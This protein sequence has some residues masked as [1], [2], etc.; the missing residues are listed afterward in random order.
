MRWLSLFL[1]CQHLNSRTNLRECED[2]SW[3]MVQ[4]V[5]VF[6][7]DVFAYPKLNTTGVVGR[8][9]P[10]ACLE[11]KNKMA[12]LQTT[13]L[14]REAATERQTCRLAVR[15]AAGNSICVNI[16][17]L[18]LT[19]RRYFAFYWAHYGPCSSLSHFIWFCNILKCRESLARCYSNAPSLYYWSDY[20]PSV[21]LRNCSYCYLCLKTFESSKQQT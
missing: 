4:A 8:M 17:L 14:D 20:K 12:P 16:S 9:G 7:F 3:F 11:A 2:Q 15:L 10:R 5:P 21:T 13:L 1:A 6:L 18:R 19:I